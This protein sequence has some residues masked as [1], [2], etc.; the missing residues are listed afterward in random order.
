MHSIRNASTEATH[1][2]WD[3]RGE[4]LV[5]IPVVHQWCS[6]WLALVHAARLSCRRRFRCATKSSLPSHSQPS[7]STHLLLN[8]DAD[9]LEFSRTWRFNSTSTNA[10]GNLSNA[11]GLPIYV[12]PV[13]PF[14]ASHGELYTAEVLFQAHEVFQG[15]PGSKGGGGGGAC[16]GSASFWYGGNRSR[17]F[18]GDGG[19]G[20]N[21]GQAGKRL[22][23]EFSVHGRHVFEAG[24]QADEPRFSTPPLTPTLTLES[25]P[26]PKPAGRRGGAVF[27]ILRGAEHA[28]VWHGA[29]CHGEQGHRHVRGR[30][31]E[32]ERGGADSTLMAAVWAERSKPAG[33]DAVHVSGSRR[34]APTAWPA[35]YCANRAASE[36]ALSSSRRRYEMTGEFEEVLVT[37]EV[38]WALV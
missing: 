11:L 7:P 26:W 35:P 2:S 31:R 34:A 27:R 14:N 12:L 6:T 32:R 37:L 19:G 21:G 17:P 22:T 3:G 28:A 20:G 8:S 1:E 10:S 38:P 9:R 18:F 36:R 30:V 29:V 4:C 13:A 33:V 5:R 16:Q 25:S 24:L 15:V 23:W